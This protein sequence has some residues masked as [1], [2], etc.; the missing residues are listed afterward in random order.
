MENAL[1]GIV[2]LVRCFLPYFKTLKLEKFTAFLPQSI[3]LFFFLKIIIL[4]R[5][6]NS[7]FNY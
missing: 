6:I 2:I 5:N 1:L 7:F 3:F 4:L